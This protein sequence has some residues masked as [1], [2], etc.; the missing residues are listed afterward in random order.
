[1]ALT[2]SHR[3]SAE[4]QATCPLTMSSWF[5]S[6]LKAAEGLLQQVDKQAQKAAKRDPITGGWHL[7]IRHPVK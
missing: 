3:N 1:M 2:A 6:Q 7:C 4:R 5:T